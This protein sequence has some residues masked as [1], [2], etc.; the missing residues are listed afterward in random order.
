LGIAEDDQIGQ[1]YVFGRGDLVEINF[2]VTWTSRYEL[3]E[4]RMNE[5]VVASV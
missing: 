5:Y 3:K 4:V 2:D 1:A